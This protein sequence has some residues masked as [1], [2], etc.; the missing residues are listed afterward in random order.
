MKK[1]ETIKVLGRGTFGEAILAERKSS[2]EK[3]VIKK[4]YMPMKPIENIKEAEILK[5]MNHPNIVKYVDGFWEK[6]YLYIVMEYADGGDLSQKIR[7]FKNNRKEFSEDEILHDFI[8]LAFAIKYI[9]DRKIL[10]RDL[11]PQNVFLMKDGTI[12]LGDFGI[13]RPLENTY[14][15]CATKCGTPGYSSPEVFSGEPYG[16]KADIWS[17]GCILYELCCLKPPFSGKTFEAIN[18]SVSK[19]DFEPIPSIYSQDIQKLVKSML[20]INPSNRPNINDILNYPIVKSNL[21]LYVDKRYLNFEMNH[22]VIH[23][24]NPYDAPTVIPKEIDVNVT[25]IGDY[26][27][28][29]TD[30]IKRFLEIPYDTEMS[31]ISNS[32]TKTIEVNDFT[33]NIKI[34]DTSGIKVFRHLT[35]FYCRSANIVIIVFSLGNWNE[36]NENSFESV[37]EFYQM[38]VEDNKDAMICLCGNMSDIPAEQ[39][40]ISFEEGRR[41]A[42]ELSNEVEYFETSAVTGDGINVMFEE[43]IKKYLVKLS[44]RKMPNNDNEK[45]KDSK[46]IIS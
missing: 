40:R 13:A 16:S 42:M 22:T 28:G 3:F 30:I 4:M 18:A 27:V 23:G 10:H 12:K 39:R 25:I 6:E 32:L 43:M 35:R 20:S 38:A 33:I 7:C 41:K 46:C 37:K 11:K 44:E 8:Q 26:A 5:S 24:R 19:G 34:W 2:K 14:E 9:H 17:L 29:K 45:Q 1:Y 31:A 36:Y 15:L 21:E